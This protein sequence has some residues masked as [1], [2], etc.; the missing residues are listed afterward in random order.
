MRG[1]REENP[2][3]YTSEFEAQSLVFPKDKENVELSRETCVSFLMSG[4]NH[5]ADSLFES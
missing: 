2:L 5:Q 1:R 4:Y 3:N